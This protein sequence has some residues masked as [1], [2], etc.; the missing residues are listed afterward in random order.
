MAKKTESL[1]D[2]ARKVSVEEVEEALRK[3]ARFEMLL[4]PQKKDELRAAAERYG[5]SMADYLTRLHDLLGMR[6]RERK[7]R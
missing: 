1:E 2:A 5:L 3:T 6:T 7:G 4:T